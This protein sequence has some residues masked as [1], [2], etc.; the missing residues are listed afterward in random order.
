[1]NLKFVFAIMSKL[2]FYTSH[3]T[4]NFQK[5]APILKYFTTHFY[6]LRR[7]TNG[8][9]WTNFSISIQKFAFLMP[10]WLLTELFYPINSKKYS[11]PVCLTGNFFCTISFLF[12][13]SRYLKRNT[14]LFGTAI[15]AFDHY[16][17]ATTRW[18]SAAAGRKGVSS[19]LVEEIGRA[20]CRERVL[21][22]V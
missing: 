18:A 9:I 19:C 14:Q 6:Q 1:M 11:L 8:N 22:L 20:S 2:Y 15:N 7:L 10:F 13:F 5:L 3:F 12:S 16:G 4:D 17:A 21:N